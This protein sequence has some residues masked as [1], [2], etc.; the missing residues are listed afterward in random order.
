M[1]SRP[2]RIFNRKHEEDSAVSNQT[3][4]LRRVRRTMRHCSLP[5]MLFS[6]LST[7]AAAS[8]DDPLAYPRL[9]AQRDLEAI[10]VI[11]SAGDAQEVAA[12]RLAAAF[13]SV[14][15]ARKACAEG[16]HDDAIAIYDSISFE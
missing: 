11:E 1:R 15:E 4:I 6:L 9:C 14:M 3:S 12:A 8:P 13:F 5:V 16:R 2:L 7:A 10:S